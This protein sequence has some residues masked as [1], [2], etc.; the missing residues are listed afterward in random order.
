MFTKLE[1]SLNSI[2]FTKSLQSAKKYL[3]TFASSIGTICSQRRALYEK[4]QSTFA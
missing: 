2:E 3:S 1:E 4:A